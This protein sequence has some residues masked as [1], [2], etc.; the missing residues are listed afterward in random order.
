MI[1]DNSDSR[2]LLVKTLLRKFPAALLQE[3]HD[4]ATA[5]TAAK[6]DELTAIVA[7]R[8]FECDGITLVLHLRNLNPTVPIVMVSG[9]DRTSQALAAGANA[10][11]NYDEWLRVGTVV[12]EVIGES[13][14]DASPREEPL[15][16]GTN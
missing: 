14:S 7:H 2:F 5:T 3:C 10:F 16:R 9:T 6:T 4:Y 8:T 11:L 15:P 1:D 13:T 12:S